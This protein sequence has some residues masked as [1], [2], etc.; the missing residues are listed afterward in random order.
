MRLELTRRA[1]YA[2]RAMLALSVSDE[3]VLSGP[4]IAES[5][6]IPPRFIGQVM[7][8]LVKAGLVEARTG[9]NGGYRIT[10]PADSISILSVIE[11]A[12]DQT[13]RGHCVL[14]GG[15]CAADG[16]CPVHPI[17]EA[18]HN[19]LLERLTTATL[20]SAQVPR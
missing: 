2:I 14:R 16:T 17:F 1:D 11:A 6:D 12:G 15:P 5:M 4:R 7:G 20:A 18:A 9:R 10:R 19:A 13:G 8:Q 3:E